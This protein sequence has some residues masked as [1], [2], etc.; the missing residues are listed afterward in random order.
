MNRINSSYLV[1]EFCHFVCVGL[2]RSAGGGHTPASARAAPG[3]WPA[4]RRWGSR[5]SVG[6][7]P[8][9]CRRPGPCSVPP[10]L[11]PSLPV[12]LAPRQ[13]LRASVLPSAS[14]TVPCPATQCSRQLSV[15]GHRGSPAENSASGRVTSPLLLA[16][17]QGICSSTGLP[18]IRRAE[19]QKWRG[20]TAPGERSWHFL[21]FSFFSFLFL[22]WPFL[23]SRAFSRGDSRVSTDTLRVDTHTSHSSRTCDS[24]EF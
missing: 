18:E 10:L 20:P 16:P 19:P 7:W 13:A 3:P 24:L 9:G 14:V 12:P 21:P 5:R 11:L 4:R 6:A 15:S 23:L 8:W 1:S 22:K 2:V 17:A